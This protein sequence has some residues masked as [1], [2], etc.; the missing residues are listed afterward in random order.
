MNALCG[1]TI[2]AA[3]HIYD[4][5]RVGWLVLT[6]SGALNWVSNITWI[7]IH[8]VKKHKIRWSSNFLDPIFNSLGFF[9]ETIILN[10]V[11]KLYNMSRGVIETY[12]G[13]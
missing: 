7:W 2:W 11:P 5:A 1:L 9:Y 12:V 10:A 8:Y 4:P 3:R 13:A 6:G